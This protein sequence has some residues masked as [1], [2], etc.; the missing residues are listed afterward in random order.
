MFDNKYFHWYAASGLILLSLAV[1]GSEYLIFLIAYMLFIPWFD[2][3]WSKDNP[4]FIRVKYSIHLWII[5]L[6]CVT[7]LS[8]FDS[9]LWIFALTTVAMAALPEEWFFRAYLQ[10][11]LGNSYIAIL[12]SSAC[13][14][15]AHMITVSWLTGILVFF[16]S[17]LFGYIYK[18]TGDLVLVVLL[19]TVSNVFYKVY[20]YDWLNKLIN[21]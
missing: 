20:G 21:I 6:F 16:P 12:T 9:Q 3:G 14:S 15:L 1:S 18:K 11:R 13:F 8:G 10:S 5:S 4:R 17:L 19:H 7:L 2:R